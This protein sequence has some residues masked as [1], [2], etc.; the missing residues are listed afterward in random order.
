MSIFNK[1]RWYISNAAQDSSVNN[2]EN[3]SSSQRTDQVDKLSQDNLFDNLARSMA[4]SLTR[5]DALKIAVTGLT[6]IALSK[7][8]INN[9]WALNPCSCNGVTYDIN[10]SC[11]TPT[12]IVPKFPITDLSKCPDKVRN[13]YYTCISNGCGAQGGIRF[14]SSFGLANFLDACNE[15]DC[16]WGRCNSN[17][18]A[19]DE[20]FHFKLRE[21]CLVHQFY[22][23]LEQCLVVAQ[24]YYEAV[25]SRFGNSPYENAQ[26]GACHCC[27]NSSPC[28]LV[29]CLDGYCPDGY[30]C[31]GI[32][33]GTH[34]V[35]CS[36][37]GFHCVCPS[38][39]CLREGL[40]YKGSC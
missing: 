3:K 13:P 15:H 9:S 38:G 2:F 30:Y 20:N 16:C 31:W 36:N 27:N 11:C 37:V 22:P 1:I 40:C 12:G 21:A 23:L 19:C 33:N 7:L 29:K 24:I 26:K 18:S 6:G 14:P 10:I 34:P 17:R 32:Y 39:Y 8:G 28:N 5:R 35:C 4:G 25:A